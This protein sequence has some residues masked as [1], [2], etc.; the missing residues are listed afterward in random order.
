MIKSVIF[1]IGNVLVDFTWEK[2]FCDFGLEGEAFEKVAN[3]TVRHPGWLELD[4]GSIT[5]EEAIE[6]FSKEAPEYRKHIERI[7]IE[8]VNMLKQYDYAIPWIKELKERGYKVYILSNWSK[9]AYEA[10]K[11]NALNFL[12][13]V[14]GAILSYQE[15]LVKPDQKIYERICTRYEIDPKEA[16]FLD[17]VI[18]NIEGARAYGLHAIHFQS[19]EQ[20]KA[21]LE[22]LLKK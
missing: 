22:E 12:P 11:D 21:E 17:D 18:K 3:A 16:V 9:P 20:A 10:C 19:Y 13:L 8:L 14:D 2:A 1:D 7:Y 15:L 6:I 4:R 5:K